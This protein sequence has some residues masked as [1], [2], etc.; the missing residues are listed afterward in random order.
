VHK[1][2]KNFS[3][4]TFIYPKDLFIFTLDLVPEIK[5]LTSLAPKLLQV[6][7]ERPNAAFLANR[8]PTNAQHGLD[9]PGTHRLRGAL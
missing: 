1:S 8:H 4:K 3:A 5:T 9:P 6:T 7:P 2:A